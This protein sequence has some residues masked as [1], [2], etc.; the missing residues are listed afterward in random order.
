[1][2]KA[3]ICRIQVRP[4]PNAD[5]IQL[6]TA[7]GFQVVVGLDTKEGDLGIYFPPDGQLSDEYCKANNLYPTLDENGKRVGGGFIEPSN[8]RVRAQGFRGEKSFGLWMPISS[9]DYVGDAALALQEG[10]ELTDVEEFH[11]C[12]RYET[13]ATRK[14]A[15]NKAQGKKQ[16]KSIMFPEHVDTKQFKYYVDDIP[17][18]S[19]ITITE[20]I[21][22]TSGRYGHVVVNKPLPWWA[23]VLNYFGCEIENKEWSYL[24]G[25][26]R[27]VLGESKGAGYYG[28]DDFRNEATRSIVLHKG[29]VIYFELV[30]YVNESSTIMPIV[31]NSTLGKEFVSRYGDYTTY[32]YGTVPGECH[33]YVY[34]ITVNNEDG[35]VV[36]LSWNQVKARCKELGLKYVPEMDNELGYMLKSNQ[37]YPLPQWI[38]DGDSDWLK[39]VV[40]DFTDGPSTI[41]NEHIREGVVIRVDQPNG[42]TKFYK[43]KSHDFYVLEGII[44]DSNI[45]DMEEAN[46]IV[47][48]EEHLE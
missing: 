19:L 30:G 48:S 2:Y 9:L 40:E 20:K 12:N 10:E 13:P 3:I 28:T 16:P 44:K 34:R 24:N 31:N 43:N 1:M 38:Y 36:E 15:R 17:V 21:H 39:Q 4:H 6:G 35:R 11:I 7:M 14:A 26:R 46:D 25:S 23:K 5:R 32:K 47:N 22:G 41:D 42:E 29:E 18:G 45:V 8:R 37:F 33:L 27:V